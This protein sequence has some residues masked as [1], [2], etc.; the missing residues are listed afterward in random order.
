MYF[1]FF[2]LY[3]FVQYKT[4]NFLEFINDDSVKDNNEKI[5]NNSKD[6]KIDN[7][8]QDINMIKKQNEIYKNK[9]NELEN[10]IKNLELI[11]KEKDN[12]INEFNKI[13]EFKNVS[14]NNNNYINRIK[15]LEIEI[16]KYKN[17]CLSP[18]EKLITI[19]FISTDK[20]INFNTFAKKSDLF[21]KL[22]TI[23]YEYYP[24][25]KGTDNYF[26]VNGKRVSKLK[27]IEDNK[28]NDNDILTLGI[29][30]E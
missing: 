29:F 24:K 21:T 26:L 28:I 8:N 1:L 17:Y 23:L 15:E 12:K 22:E 9:I 10:K 13:K 11:I 6:N 2:N 30:D 3:L 20:T 7:D 4:K 16:E 14:N 18:G 25:Y 5:N 27:T 19:N